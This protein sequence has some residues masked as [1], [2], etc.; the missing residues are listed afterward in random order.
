DEQRP[1]SSRAHR[2]LTI[3]A[4]RTARRTTGGSALPAAGATRKGLKDV[5]K[6]EVKTSPASHHH[7][8]GMFIRSR[9]AA[10]APLRATSEQDRFAKATKGTSGHVQ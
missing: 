1:L 5:F 10:L 3:A 4:L 2:D 9:M 8:Q 6:N 7:A